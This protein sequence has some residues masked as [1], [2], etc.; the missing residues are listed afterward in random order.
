MVNFYPDLQDTGTVTGEFV[1]VIDRSGTVKYF[2]DH[3]CLSAYKGWLQETITCPMYKVQG[4]VVQ[5]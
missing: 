4:P 3:Y 2:D 5:S 1:F